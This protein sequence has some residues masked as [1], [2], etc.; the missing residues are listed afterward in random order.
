MGIDNIDTVTK[1][2][3]S[4][5]NIVYFELMGSDDYIYSAHILYKALFHFLQIINVTSLVIIQIANYNSQFMVDIITILQL[6]RCLSL[7][8]IVNNKVFSIFRNCPI[9]FINITFK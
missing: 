2:I 3:N 1:C 5:F 6:Q 8:S 4:V 7:T 9:K